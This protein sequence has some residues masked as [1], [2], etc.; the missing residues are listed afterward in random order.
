VAM[1]LVLHQVLFKQ[2]YRAITTTSST[3][4]CI[5]VCRCSSCKNAPMLV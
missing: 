3:Q 2:S 1:V 4:S 5:H